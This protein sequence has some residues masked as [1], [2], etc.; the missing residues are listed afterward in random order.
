VAVVAAGRGGVGDLRATAGGAGA[1]VEDVGVAGVTFIGWVAGQDR[2]GRDLW[3]TSTVV[4]HGGL[5]ELA[6]ESDPTTIAL[7]CDLATSMA[8]VARVTRPPPSEVPFLYSEDGQWLLRQERELARR[9]PVRYHVYLELWHLETTGWMRVPGAWDSIE[10]L[11]Q[12]VRA[13]FEE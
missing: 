1:E 13:L 5:L 11:P 7:T 8:T 3:G 10:D 12:R 9:R 6:F 4:G 2:A